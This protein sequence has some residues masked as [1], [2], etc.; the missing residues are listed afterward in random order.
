[1]AFKT[2]NPSS[3]TAHPDSRITLRKWWCKRLSFID[4]GS[5]CHVD[6]II[7]V[8][9]DNL[10]RLV[11][12]LSDV[13]PGRF[14]GRERADHKDIASDRRSL[15]SRRGNCHRLIILCRRHGD[16]EQ[17]FTRDRDRRINHPLDTRA[18]AGVK[19]C[20]IHTRTAHKACR[21]I[22]NAKPDNHSYNRGDNL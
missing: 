8:H 3:A 22:K 6:A 2:G 20:E 15:L 13:T 4:V 11:L 5:R 16:V 9:L 14:L 7:A 1:M 18:Y 21:R 19:R 17:Y 12:A 10:H